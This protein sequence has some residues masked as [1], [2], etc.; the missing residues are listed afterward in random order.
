MEISG[1]DLRVLKV[2]L[3]TSYHF[4]LYAEITMLF[5][6]LDSFYVSIKLVLFCFVFIYFSLYADRPVDNNG[7]P[8]LLKLKVSVNN[9]PVGCVFASAFILVLC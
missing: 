3:C 5:V 9:F 1:K 2:C 6:P 4:P 8:M 7:E